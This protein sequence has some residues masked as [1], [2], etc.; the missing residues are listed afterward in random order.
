MPALAPV[1]PPDP[2][3]FI[4]TNHILHLLLTFMTCGLWVFGWVAVHLGHEAGNRMMK[5]RYE[6]NMAKYRQYQAEVAE[7]QRQMWIQ[8]QSQQR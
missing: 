7:Y 3:S 8:Q 6:V 4:E 2:P 1:M 5:E